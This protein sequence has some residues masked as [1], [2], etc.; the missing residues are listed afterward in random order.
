MKRNKNILIFSLLGVLVVMSIAYAAFSTALSISSTAT[1]NT[2]WNVGFDT[3]KTSGTGVI[4]PT[5]GKTGATAPTGSITFPDAQHATITTTLNQPGDKVVYTFTIKNTG[6]LA[7]TLSAPTL[8]SATGCTISG[9]VCTSTNGYLKITAADPAS[10]S[11]AASTGSTTMTVTVEFPSVSVSNL[12]SGQS[13]SVTIGLT[14]T[15]A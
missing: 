11:L 12:T 1:I 14:A 5:T 2:S 6:S 8:S 3:T 7:A 13:A 15:Q 9:K 4:T 10:S